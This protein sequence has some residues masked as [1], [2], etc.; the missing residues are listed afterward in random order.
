MWKWYLQR[1]RLWSVLLLSLCLAVFWY[2][3][4]PMGMGGQAAY[5]IIRGN[6]MEPLYHTGDL[7]I[8]RHETRAKVGDVF[9]YHYP[10]IGTVIHRIVDIQGDRYMFQ[11]DNNDWLDGYHPTREDFI[12]KVWIHIAEA[13]NVLIW[14]REPMNISLVAALLGGTLMFGLVSNPSKGPDHKKKRFQLPK[15]PIKDFDPSSREAGLIFLSLLLFVSVILGLLAFTRPATLTESDNISYTHSMAFDYTAKANSNVYDQPTIQAGE[16][17]FLELNCTLDVSMVYVLASTEPINVSGSYRTLALVSEP[18]GWKRTLELISDTPLVDGRF[19]AQASVDVCGIHRLIEQ[20]TELTGANRN[21]YDVEFVTEIELTG[22][23]GEHAFHENVS[24]SLN[25][26]LD[27]VQLYLQKD[28]LEDNELLNWESSGH[29]NRT[30]RV[31]NTLSLLGLT[32]PVLF[33]RIFAIIGLVVSVGGGILL[34][35]PLLSP[36]KNPVQTIHARYGSLIIRAENLPTEM[37]SNPAIEV[38]NMDDLARLAQQSGVLILETVHGSEHR[39]SV[40]LNTTI[41]SYTAQNEPEAS[42]PVK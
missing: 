25:F 29:I 36:S 21:T 8:L 31:S 5:V 12:G 26:G 40:I 3:F 4:A 1:N 14:L 17:L 16:P 33:V 20:M 32:L 37:K 19:G 38:Q 30:K 23:I 9:A 18:N 39:F 7:V 11:G 42:E 10:E 24:P 27:P 15:I 22:A 41:Y 34:S 28:G 13:G 6:S 2:L 35:L